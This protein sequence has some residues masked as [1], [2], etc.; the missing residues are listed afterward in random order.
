MVA[1]PGQEK[2]MTNFTGKVTTL[3]Q[4]LS[5]ISKLIAHPPGKGRMW[6]NPQQQGTPNSPTPLYKG[7]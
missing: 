2:H 1:G 7:G 5:P 3:M 4:K 6:E